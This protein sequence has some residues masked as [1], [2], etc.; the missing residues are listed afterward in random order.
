MG[1]ESVGG[2]QGGIK[3]HSVDAIAV[4]QG[5]DVA[6]VKVTEVEVVRKFNSEY[7]LE[8]KIEMIF[9]HWM[10]AEGLE[11]ESRVKDAFKDFV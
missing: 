10:K 6:W 9:I 1:Q 8:G 7:V 11:R 4:T 5:T 3:E 2:G